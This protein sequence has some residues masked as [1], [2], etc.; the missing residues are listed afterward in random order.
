M[1]S[2]LMASSIQNIHKRA[3]VRVQTALSNP[4]EIFVKSRTSVPNAAEGK[5]PH[6]AQETFKGSSTNKSH[7]RCANTHHQGSI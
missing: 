5:P 3:C 1:L 6:Y 4:M 7:A 2:S